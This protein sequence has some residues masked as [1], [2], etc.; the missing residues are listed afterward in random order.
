V[1]DPS[2]L[3]VEVRQFGIVSESTAGHVELVQVCAQDRL[4]SVRL[5]GACVRNH[6][7]RHRSQC[8]KRT[9]LYGR[10]R[11][12]CVPREVAPDVATGRVVVVVGGGDVVVVV[13]ANVG[14]VV[15]GD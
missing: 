6:Q 11:V 9:L 4:G 8:A 5:G 7:R 3:P 13:G 1:G 12:Q 15:A 2:G 10:G 14:C